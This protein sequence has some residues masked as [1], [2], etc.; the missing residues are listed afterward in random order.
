MH[1]LSFF[2]NKNFVRKEF[3]KVG[4]FPV[5]SKKPGMTQ[6]SFEKRINS[7]LNVIKQIEKKYVS[8]ILCAMCNRHE[9]NTQ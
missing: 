1:S 8:F 9:V 6:K 7:A 2:S 5:C 4:E 3:Q